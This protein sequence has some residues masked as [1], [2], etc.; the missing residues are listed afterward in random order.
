MSLIATVS[1]IGT[2][3]IAIAFSLWMLKETFTGK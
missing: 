1:A 3:V 2:V